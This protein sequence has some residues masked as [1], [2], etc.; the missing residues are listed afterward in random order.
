VLERGDQI[1]YT[2]AN[3]YD[4]LVLHTGR[5]LSA[6][7][8]LPIPAS[9]S[10]FPPRRDFVDYL[11]RYAETFQLPI[12]L[13]A[14][15]T[16][17]ERADDR[18]LVHLRSGGSLQARAVVIA[19]GIVANPYIPEIPDRHLFKGGVT[20]SVHYRRPQG[21]RGQRVLVVG[22]GNSAGEISV[23]IARAGAQVTLAVQSG[24][25][26]VPR[27]IAGV[28]IQYLSVALSPLPKP[29]FDRVAALMNGVSRL[30]RG[31]SGLP[32]PAPTSCPKVPLIGLALAEALRAGTI[33]L[34]GGLRSFTPAGVRFA[35]GSERP[36]DQVILATGYR[37][38]VGMLDGLI[39]LD[40]CGFAER[41]DRVVSADQPG[42]Y[43]VG[44]NYDTRGGLFNIARD[45]RRAASRIRGSL[46]DTAR[47]STERPRAPSGR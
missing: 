37:A 43:F 10:L 15:A 36:F 22:A 8:G 11:H 44:H 4:S 34:R 3:L 27:E 25:R 30:L 42:L 23:E 17:V 26:I 19:T 14:E 32:P 33:E 31:P 47:T 38:A 21:L 29:V 16:R 13:G 45:S 9:A 12:E 2:W 28:P 24:A 39:R 20:H 40:R 35:D 7:P 1:G 46:A 18:W 41:R 6:L 5:H